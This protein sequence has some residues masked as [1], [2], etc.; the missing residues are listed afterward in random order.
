MHIQEMFKKLDQDGGGTL[1]I[2]EITSL[3]KANG[4]HM[5]P[6]EVAD[7]FANAMRCHLIHEHRKQL[8]KFRM[9]NVARHLMQSKPTELNLKQQMNPEQF[10]IVASSP[11]ALGQVKQG[12]TKFK[13]SLQLKGG[14][15]NYVPTTM[16]ELMG[17]FVLNIRRLNNQEEFE[18]QRKLLDKPSLRHDSE[19]AITDSV[20][21]CFQAL[22]NLMKAPIMD[23]NRQPNSENNLYL[24]L[25]TKA[26]QEQG[27]LVEFNQ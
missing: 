16:D 27:R 2:E 15:S 5:S 11:A 8:M 25:L 22:D 20:Q 4:I 19:D 23:A 1:S 17:R 21:K 13:A 12:L 6:D 7:M 10:R 26:T 3:F 14:C 18:L 9:S 24:K